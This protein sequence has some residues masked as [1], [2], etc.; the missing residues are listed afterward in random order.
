MIHFDAVM[1]LQEQLLL[2]VILLK[3][4]LQ[5]LQCLQNL[6]YIFF[7]LSCKIQLEF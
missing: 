1:K 2:R 4:F 7:Q 3:I 5:F 6:N